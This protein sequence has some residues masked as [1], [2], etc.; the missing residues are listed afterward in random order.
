MPE[1]TLEREAIQLELYL[2]LQS[3]DPSQYG[4]R[5]H[6]AAGRPEPQLGKHIAMDTE[7]TLMKQ[8]DV[9]ALCMVSIG[10]GQQH[11]VAKPDQLG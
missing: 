7:T 11:Y 1:A 4:T 5:W 3:F 8:Q 9:P 2:P 6:C 10:D